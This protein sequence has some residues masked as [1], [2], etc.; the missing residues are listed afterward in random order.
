MLNLSG[1]KI[2]NF[3]GVSLI[4]LSRFLNIKNEDNA[5]INNDDVNIY[6]MQKIRPLISRENIR[7]L[8]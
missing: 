1:V 8:N 5:P 3:K 6:G 7:G 4:F 2:C